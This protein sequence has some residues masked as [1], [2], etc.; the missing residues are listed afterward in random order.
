MSGR[1]TARRPRRA[2]GDLAWMSSS[3]TLRS[4]RGRVA[5]NQRSTSKN[6]TRTTAHAR[7]RAQRSRFCA[8]HTRCSFT[9]STRPQL[10]PRKGGTF[11][12]KLTFLISSLLLVLVAAGVAYTKRTPA[13]AS[14]GA[15]KTFAVEARMWGWTPTSIEVEE[16]DRVVLDITTKDVKQGLSIQAIDL[17]VEL[18]AGKTTREGFVAKESG[19]CR[20]I[21]G[22][23]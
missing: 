19:E 17:D 5:L 18:A 23:G 22:R 15:L 11:V 13:V 20:L 3:T 9:A 1:S 2:R 6:I 10:G 21:G 14:G 16:G 12:R 7:L 8:W 4:R